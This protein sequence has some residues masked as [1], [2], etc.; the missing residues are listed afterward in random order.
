MRHEILTPLQISQGLSTM[1]LLDWPRVSTQ[2]TENMSS[3]KGLI[4]HPLGLVAHLCLMD[5]LCIPALSPLVLVQVI[6]EY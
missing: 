3:F 6:F 2:Q 4:L 1:H 5:C